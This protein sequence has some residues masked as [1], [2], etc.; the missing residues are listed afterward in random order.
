M[1]STC[2]RTTSMPPLRKIKTYTT[3][4]E[5]DINCYCISV[6]KSES[7]S[8]RETVRNPESVKKIQNEKDRRKTDIARNCHSSLA[9]WAGSGLKPGGCR[10]CSLEGRITLGSC[11]T[12]DFSSHSHTEPPLA[13]QICHQTPSEVALQIEKVC[14]HQRSIRGDR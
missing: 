10:P 6:T 12:A 1:I 14:C 9:V 2:C 11:M 3:W 5:S 8:K 7:E 13:S 4:I